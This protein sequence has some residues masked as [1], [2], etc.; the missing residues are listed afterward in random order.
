M[1]LIESFQIDHDVL[2]PGLYISR[3]DFGDTVTYDLRF[4]RPNAGDY[5]SQEAMHT[6]EHLL[7]TYIRSSELAENAV[8]IGPMGCQ[9]GFYVLFRDA[10]KETAVRIIRQA[11]AY[12]KDYTGEIPGTQPSQCGNY[13]CHDLA[14]A[15]KEADAYFRVIEH[16][17]S[18]QLAYPTRDEKGNELC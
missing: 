16:W 3:I 9:T 18:A 15:R 11:M 6:I 12:I 10:D 14:A 5:L 17:T 2:T 8:Y 13:R 7:A 1:K 4:K